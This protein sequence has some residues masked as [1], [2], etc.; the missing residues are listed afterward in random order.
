MILTHCY[1]TVINNKN[2]ALIYTL[3][4]NDLNR[5]N[6]R[7]LMY[8]TVKSTGVHINFISRKKN[9]FFSFTS[10]KSIN[11]IFTCSIFFRLNTFELAENTLISE[12]SSVR[13]WWE[14]RSVSFYIFF[15]I[16]TPW[17]LYMKT[18]CPLHAC[19]TK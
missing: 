14:I 1:N 18:T 12:N 15:H 9:I 11:Q 4:L 2:L 10:M 5:L 17:M 13:K 3:Q 16:R 6:T 8:F 7:W 19:L